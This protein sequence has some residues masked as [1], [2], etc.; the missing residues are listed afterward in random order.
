MWVFVADITNEFNLGLDILRAYNASVDIGRQ[1][2]RLAEE[3]VPL[4]SP[5][6]GPRPSSL[7]VPKDHVIPAQCEKIVM[8]RMENLLGVE[9]GLVEPNPQGHPP[10]GIYV[11]RNLVQDRQEVPVRVLNSTRR[12]QKLTRGS[13]LAHCEPVTLVTTPDVK[14]NRAQV[15]RSR[16]KDIIPE[17]KPHLTKEEFHELGE[18]LTEYQDIYAGNNEDYSRT[19]KVYHCIDTGDA[20]PIRQHPRRLPLAKQAEVSEMLDDMQRREVIEESDSPWSSPDVLVRKKNGELRFCVDYRKLNDVTK[21]DCFPLPRIDDTL[22]TLA[23][24]NW[25]STLDLKSGYWQVD[26]HPDDK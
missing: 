4:R 5:G 8:A 7:V 26:V 20:R 21:K 6:S 25:F 14:Q 1:T 22:D 2:M 18:L 9:N 10:E 23:G 16:L 13:T 11:A 3:E 19:N 15:P 12:D 24:A 17:A